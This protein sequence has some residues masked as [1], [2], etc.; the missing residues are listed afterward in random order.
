V[1]IP[2][3]VTWSHEQVPEEAL[4]RAGWHRLDSIAELGDLLEA[5]DPG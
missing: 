1:H 5:L 3:D 2:Y 4:P